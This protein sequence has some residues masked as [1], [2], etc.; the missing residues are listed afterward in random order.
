MLRN[1]R[2]IEN[3]FKAELHT[4]ITS[5]GRRITLTELFAM[6]VCMKS[7]NGWVRGRQTFDD[8]RRP[9]G[10]LWAAMARVGSDRPSPLKK[11]DCAQDTA[12][13]P[14]PP[15]EGFSSS[16]VDGGHPPPSAPLG[17]FRRPPSI[18]RVSSVPYRIFGFFLFFCF[19]SLSEGVLQNVRY[20]DFFFGMMIVRVYSYVFL[21]V[22]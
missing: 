5:V 22:C 12:H 15:S 21:Y 13:M 10:C 14:R 2:F 6:G 20:H 17:S 11:T 9:W 7:Q 1:H 4:I 8:Y 3:D 18:L 19:V 16:S